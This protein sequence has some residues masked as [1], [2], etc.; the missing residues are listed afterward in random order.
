MERTWNMIDHARMHKGIKPYECEFC[1]KKFTQKGNMKKHTKLHMTENVDHRRKY[2]CRFCGRKYTEKYNL[3]VGR[4]ITFPY[5]KKSFEFHSY[6]Q[7]VYENFVLFR[8]L[9]T[10]Y[11]C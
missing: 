8:V 9:K 6:Q 4:C 2:P 5:N 10:L 1:G 11:S 3:M 7:Y